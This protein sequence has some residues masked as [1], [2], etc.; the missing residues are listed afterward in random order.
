[1]ASIR[2]DCQIAGLSPHQRVILRA[3]TSTRRDAVELRASYSIN[4]SP[5]TSS[6]SGSEDGVTV[7]HSALAQVQEVDLRLD[8]EVLTA[9]AV[10]L[11]PVLVGSN[12]G[13]PSDV[14]LPPVLDTTLS[15]ELR[16]ISAA[17]AAEQSR[18]LVEDLQ[19]RPI[20]LLIG[21]HVAPRPEAALGAAAARPSVSLLLAQS[22]RLLGATVI[23]AEQVPVRLPAVTMRGVVLPSSAAFGRELGNKYK[24]TLFHQAYL[25]LIPSSA[26]LGDPYGMLRKLYKGW[27]RARH[28]M[29]RSSWRQLP[30]VMA[31][32]AGRLVQS[33]VSNALRAAGLS[34]E[35][36]TRS[37]TANLPV[38]NPNLTLLEAV[39]RGVG[40]VAREAALGAEAL[41]VRIPSRAPFA[42][43]C[44][45]LPVAVPLGSLRSVR[46]L[47]FMGLVGGLS[48]MRS[49][50]DAFRAVVK[51]VELARLGARG[52]ASR[53][54]APRPV[55]PGQLL[56]PRCDPA[57]LE[58]GREL[59]E[60]ARPGAPLLYAVQTA[61]AEA[62]VLLTPTAL[63]CV[64]PYAPDI[65][66][67]EVGLSVILLLQRRDAVVVLLCH[68]PEGSPTSSGG[69]G[70]STGAP[71]ELVQREVQA[72]TKDD[73]AALHE[74]VRVAQLN[75]ARLPVPS[76]PEMTG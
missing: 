63:L 36:V 13:G 76:Q 2:L 7:L 30:Y 46:H 37:L 39:L 24:Q 52:E 14:R 10:A 66:V 68:A 28:E 23:N 57:V 25:K 35:A 48:L 22:W 41:M 27:L 61:G 50:F 11:A 65:P 33:T 74:V 42:L 54:H 56:P 3:G 49:S 43:Q 26:V 40:G 53:T 32:C 18:I 64:R 38:D 45:L 31:H 55:P 4:S 47:L 21:L 70:S 58:A 17:P 16:S 5:G 51:G 59:L 8:E 60:S 73:A 72:S 62:M 9:V 12:A 15:D 44:I 19:L 6:I 71:R 69:A 29:Q 67:W 20:R 75:S 1:V 34:A